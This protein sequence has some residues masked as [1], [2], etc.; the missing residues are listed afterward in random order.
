MFNALSP[1]YKGLL[2]ALVGYSCFACADAGTKWLTQHYSIYQTIAMENVFSMLIILACA[3]VIGGIKSL[4]DISAQRDWR[5]HILR[6]IFTFSI[7]AVVVYSF[8]ILPLT[9]VYT[10]GFMMPFAASL[11]A[12]FIYKETIGL[13]RWISITVGFIGILIAFRPWDNPMDISLTAALALAGVPITAAILHLSAK[14]CKHSTP[15]AMGFWPIALSFIPMSLCAL[16]LE[17]APL[18]LT[19]IPVAAAAG[20][21]VGIGFLFVSLAFKIGNAANASAM[22]YVQM[23][24]GLIFGA[25]IFGDLPTASMAIGAPIIVLSGLYL[26]WHEHQSTNA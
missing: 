24:W 3:P 7:N 2:F 25:L 14:S 19:H 12:L 20:A 26:I 23:L 5:V 17:P 13:H 22:L 16:L 6:G 11:L 10:A 4:A 9:S 15:L 1:T 8:A 21:A 18:I